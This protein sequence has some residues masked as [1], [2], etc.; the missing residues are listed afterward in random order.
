MVN[1]SQSVPSTQ[2]V[3]SVVAPPIPLPAQVV[4]EPLEGLRVPEVG[5]EAKAGKARAHIAAR[6]INLSF[7][8]EG[9]ALLGNN[10][11]IDGHKDA[12]S[13]W[14]WWAGNYFVVHPTDQLLGRQ[15]TAD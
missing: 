15:P 5:V 2:V 6:N 7:K 8:L 4:E 9:T 11:E 1:T 10:V 3:S 13:F 12:S 14:I